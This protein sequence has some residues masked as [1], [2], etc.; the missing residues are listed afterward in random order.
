MP[1]GLPGLGQPEPLV[2][3]VQCGSDIPMITELGK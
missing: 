3:G 1:P 2:R